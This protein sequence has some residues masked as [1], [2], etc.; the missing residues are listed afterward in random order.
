MEDKSDLMRLVSN[1]KVL[2]DFYCAFWSDWFD[3]VNRDNVVILLV[4]LWDIW[5]DWRGRMDTR[6]HG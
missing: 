1:L 3:V 5:L 4:S 2:D 6:D